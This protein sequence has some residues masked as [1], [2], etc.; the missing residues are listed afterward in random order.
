MG[1]TAHCSSSV[2][3]TFQH[4]AA[5]VCTETTQTKFIDVDM[6]VERS[7]SGSGLHYLNFM[8]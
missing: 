6:Q 5:Y 3:S 7:R 8:R 4:A 1:Q 2:D